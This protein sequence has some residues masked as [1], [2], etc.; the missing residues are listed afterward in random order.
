MIPTVKILIRENNDMESLSLSQEHLMIRFAQLHV[1]AALKAAA[2]N[3]EINF[4]DKIDG[5]VNISKWRKSDSES[6][7]VNEASI[8]NAYPKELIQ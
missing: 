5:T 7:T 4:D 8:L 6:I 2:K 3:A 1:E